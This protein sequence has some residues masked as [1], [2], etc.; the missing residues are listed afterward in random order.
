MSRSPLQHRH[1]HHDHHVLSPLVYIK[2]LF[3]LLIL[4]GATVAVSYVHLP[5]VLFIPGNWLNNIVAMLIASVKALLVVLYFM[6]VKYSTSL[7]KLWVIAGFVWFTLLF[8]ILADYGTRR[9]EQFQGW[10]PTTGGLPQRP[11]PATE[12]FPTEGVF[13][14][15]VPR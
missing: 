2:T 3:L 8:L 11:L 15:P 6:H 1:D 13:I 7:T 9:F 4:M 10:E 5:D 12:N 14:A